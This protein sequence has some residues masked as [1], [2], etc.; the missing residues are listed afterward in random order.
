MGRKDPDAKY[1]VDL[2]LA[3][4]SKELSQ[5]IKDYATNVAL[6]HSRYMFVKTMGKIQLGYCTHCNNGFCAD[7]VRV[8]EGDA[9]TLLSKLK[10]NSYAQCPK[11]S[12][13]CQVKNEGYGH[14]NLYDK[15]YF[16]YYEKSVLDPKI[17]TARG[18][19]VTRDYC[20]EYKDIQTSYRTEALYVFEVG[21]P[22]VM[23][24]TNYLMGYEKASS[25][26]SL[27]SRFA[28]TMRCRTRTGISCSYDSIHNAVKDTPF[29]YSPY[30]F[31]MPDNTS[32]IYENDLVEFF[33][34]FSKYPVI[35]IL[36]RLGF[37]KIVDEKIN[38]QNFERALNWRSKTLHGIFRLSKQ[39]FNEL[40]AIRSSGI[41]V[42]SY[43]VILFQINKQDK[44]KLD[45]HEIHDI[46]RAFRHSFDN[47]RSVTAY[48]SLRKAYS[49]TKKQ[50]NINSKHFSCIES[51]LNDWADYLE[52]CKK[53]GYEL[54]PDIVLPK[55]LKTAHDNT[56][57]KIKYSESKELNTK[58]KKRAKELKKYCFEHNGLFIRPVENSKE[59]IVEGKI[60]RHCVGRYAK[61]VAEGRTNI[62]FIR[63]AEAPEDPFYTVEIKKAWKSEELK[64]VQCRSYKNYT[65]EENGH[66]DVS[67]FL[68]KFKAEKLER[69]QNKVRVTVPA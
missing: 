20:T 31:Y 69:K 49:Y 65:P 51:V 60:L 34:T 50:V 19:F 2:Y 36:E 37:A 29:A 43:F 62:F 38:N 39:D 1:K 54:T 46:G 44:S 42:D 7:T 22:P 12:S 32:E 4:F 27:Y 41:I 21:N 11:C 53:L 5:E 23:L 30:K 67:E 47:L 33:A 68:E 25:V 15:A 55:D 24:T 16:V 26:Y 45:A 52:D 35:E 28:F 8:R 9:S 14:S 56:I 18:I 61:D 10:H 3:H 66:K 6:L 40:R 48:V 57:K 58:I 63:K 59:L 13:W 64:I 17:I